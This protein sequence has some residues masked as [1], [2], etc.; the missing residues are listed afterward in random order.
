MSTKL[1]NFFS[2]SNLTLY[3]LVYKLEIKI[4]KNF[5]I[6]N[7]DKG[8]SIFAVNPCAR[9]T[10]YRSQGVNV[11]CSALNQAVCPAGYYC[12]IGVDSQSSVCCQ[13]IG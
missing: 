4:K 9:G 7:F 3:Y 10:P 8:N 6:C 5:F 2:F 12:H 11:Q 1:A 13:A